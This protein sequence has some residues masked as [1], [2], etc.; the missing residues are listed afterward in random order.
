MCCSVIRYRL[1]GT[2]TRK[3]EERTYIVQNNEILLKSK[4]LCSV[5]LST[6]CVGAVQSWLMHPSQIMLRFVTNRL[7]A[8][9]I[10]ILILLVLYCEE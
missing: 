5:L 4:E 8:L 2:A 9:M 7:K 3:C 1:Q 6:I 10:S